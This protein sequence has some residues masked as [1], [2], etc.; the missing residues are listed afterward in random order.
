LEIK[1]FLN[2]LVKISWLDANFEFA[3]S[4]DRLSSLSLQL[5]YNYGILLLYTSKFI[6]VAGEVLETEYRGISIIPR[7]VIIEIKEFDA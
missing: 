7:K 3:A 2:K 4:K 5:V 1:Q 6:V